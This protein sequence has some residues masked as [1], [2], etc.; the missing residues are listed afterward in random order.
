MIGNII[1]A[2]GAASGAPA[3]I[4]TFASIANFSN[5]SAESMAY[6]R[7]SG[8]L[9]CWGWYGSTGQVYK[10]QI[11]T[12]TWSNPYSSMP[13]NYAPWTF[14]NINSDGKIWAIQ[15]GS[16]S[17]G[18]N[19]NYTLYYD[20]VANSYTS[21][22][23]S[24]TTGRRGRGSMNAAGTYGYYHAGYTSAPDTA[25]YE[26]NVSGNSYTSKASFPTAT[27][28]L[29]WG[30][31]GTNDNIYA[32]LGTSSG[33]YS[34][35]IYYYVY[36]ISGNSW[37]AKTAPTNNYGGQGAYQGGKMYHFGNSSNKMSIYSISSNSWI[38]GTNTN[39]VIANG[40]PCVVSDATYIY[41]WANSTSDTS[42]YTP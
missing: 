9:Y 15:C 1:A 32:I 18:G 11:S 5:S 10:Y 38:I 14:Q 35:T 34:G 2:F 13:T 39:P 4:D 23:N 31:D 40:N 30:H 28:D 22:A 7:Y 21:K 6:G 3:P 41:T 8:A 27:Y 25:F 26:Y 20:A 12:N 37:T 36:S 17:A 29:G 16:S 19:G 42:K 24:P 33:N